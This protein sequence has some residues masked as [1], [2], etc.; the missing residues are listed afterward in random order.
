[1]TIIVGLVRDNEVYMGCDGAGTGHNYTQSKIVEPKVFS[2][3]ET[4]MGM[5]GSFRLGQ[6]LQYVLKIPDR[7]P[8]NECDMSWLVNDYVDAVRNTLKNKGHIHEKDGEFNI[9][10]GDY[11]LGYKGSLYVVED[12]FQI[13]KIDEE[14]LTTGCGL[15]LEI[16]VIQFI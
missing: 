14:Y 10:N 3:G 16:N 15:P 9:P 8:R 13:L 6:I 5:C 7:D 4:L 11:L 12:N 2:N 1:M